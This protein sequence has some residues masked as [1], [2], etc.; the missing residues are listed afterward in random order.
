M[1]YILRT[2]M[3]PNLKDSKIFGYGLNKNISTKKYEKMFTHHETGK[4]INYKVDN[5]LFLKSL[6]EDI[7][8]Y[9][10]NIFGGSTSFCTQINQ[11]DIFLKEPFQKL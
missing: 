8:K 5:D 1:S 3:Y 7:Q 4:I 9:K 2:K 6:N 11:E 10:F